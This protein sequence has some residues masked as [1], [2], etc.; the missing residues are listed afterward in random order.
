MLVQRFWMIWLAFIHISR[1]TRKISTQISKVHFNPSLFRSSESLCCIQS[2][3]SEGKAEK[4]STKTSTVTISGECEMRGIPSTIWKECIFRILK[5]IRRTCYIMFDSPHTHTLAT[6]T[7]FI[8]HIYENERKRK[9]FIQ[10]I[11]RQRIGVWSL[12]YLFDVCRSFISRS[13]S[14]TLAVQHLVRYRFMFL[15]K[16]CAQQNPQTKNVLSASQT[17]LLLLI[18]LRCFRCGF[19]NFF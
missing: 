11:V 4:K 8:R 17:L 12:Q 16:S 15:H 14:F 6:H 9:N 5:H 1:C 10:H 3:E 2:I 13:R 19:Y 18:K 7:P